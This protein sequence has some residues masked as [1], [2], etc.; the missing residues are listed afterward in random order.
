MK[1]LVVYDSMYGFTEKIANAIGSGITGEVKIV[2]VSEVSPAEAAGWDMVLV[3][4]PTQG[5][6]MLKTMQEWLDKLPEVAIKGKKAAAFDTRIPA[7]WVKLFGYAAGKIADSLK[8]KGVNLIA[9][10]EGFIV[11]GAKGP[12]IEGE[13]ERAKKW[14]EKISSL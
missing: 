13:E 8:K 3:G 9:E 6:R 7:K 10:P 14:G 11:K 5:G 4:S 12:L 1:T 2:R